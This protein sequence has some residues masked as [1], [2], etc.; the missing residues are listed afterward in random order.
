MKSRAYVGIVVCVVASILS[1][2]FAAGA[3][4]ADKNAAGDKNA[5][6]KIGVVDRN[7]VLKAYKKVET[8]YKKLEAQ[9]TQQ[10]QGIDELSK[11]IE[12]AKAAYDKDKEK[13]SPEQRTER[14]AAI[15]SDYRKYQAELQTKQADIDSQERLLMKRVTDEIDAAVTEV[16]NKEGYYLILDGNPRS[17][18]AIFYSPTIDMSQKVI[19]LLNSK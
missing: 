5:S 10:Q 9:V 14:E 8:E 1:F 15:Q 7:K 19:D 3:Q 16:G 17:G 13:L 6:Y 18:G 2:S 4:N 12:S 11:K